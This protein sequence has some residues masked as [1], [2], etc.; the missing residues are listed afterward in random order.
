MTYQTMF[1]MRD[2]DKREACRSSTQPPP[3]TAHDEDDPIS[4][5]PIKDQVQDL[6]MRFDAFWD[7]T[8]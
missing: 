1:G 5:H 7:E 3:P 8:Q 4:P 6:T 2:E